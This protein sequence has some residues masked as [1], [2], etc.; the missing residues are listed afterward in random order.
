MMS[1]VLFVNTLTCVIVIAF[2]LTVVEM[3]ESVNIALCVAIANLGGVLG[4]TFVHFY[5]S[6]WITSDLLVIGDLF[7]ESSWYCLPTKQQ[8]LLML[9]I[10]RA[11]RDF[12]LKSLGL[13]DCSLVILGS[14]SVP[15]ICLHLN[16]EYQKLLCS[17]KL[18]D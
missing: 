13:I 2:S 16:F 14:V 11:E 9:P 12:R 4:I 7:Y 15:V 10:Q 3:S 8:K 5:P 1:F 18:G 17:L 6:E